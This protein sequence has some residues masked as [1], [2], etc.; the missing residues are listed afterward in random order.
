MSDDMKLIPPPEL[1]EALRSRDRFLL[2]THVNPDG[3]A[4]G[5]SIALAMA[6]EQL[7]KK[8][9]LLDKHPMPEQYAFLPGLG[10]TVAVARA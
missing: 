10:L 7:G 1:V 4:I 3:D 9:T 2:A 6:L 5:S 8:V